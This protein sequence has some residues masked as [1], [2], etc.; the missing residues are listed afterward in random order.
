MPRRGERELLFRGSGGRRCSGIRS[1]RGDALC[2]PLSAARTPWCSPPGG[3]GKARQLPRPRVPR[4]AWQDHEL[5]GNGGCRHPKKT[6]A[7]NYTYG[8]IDAR[9]G[10]IAHMRVQERRKHDGKTK[11]DHGRESARTFDSVAPAGDLVGAEVEEGAHARGVAQ[12]RM[13]E[14]TKLALELG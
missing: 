12:V 14:Q 4:A 6:I 2:L 3:Y 8:M 13:R 9:M 7:K 10:R 11:P 1:H 5:G